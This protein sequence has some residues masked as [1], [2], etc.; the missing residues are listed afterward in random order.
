MTLV[1]NSVRSELCVLDIKSDADLSLGNTPSEVKSEA[2]PHEKKRGVEGKYVGGGVGGVGGKG[3]E[4]ASYLKL[5]HEESHSL[6]PPEPKFDRRL[7][8]SFNEVGGVLV[9][10][11]LYGVIDLTED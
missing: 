6:L 10:N 9:E 7:T 8:D 4:V 1:G 11:G 3:G 5:D 2:G